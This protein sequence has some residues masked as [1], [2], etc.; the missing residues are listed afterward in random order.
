MTKLPNQLLSGYQKYL[1][2]REHDKAAIS[3]AE[4]PKQ[5]PDTLVI[6][7][8]EV[9]I[10]AELIFCTNPDEVMVLRSFNRTGALNGE[11]CEY[12]AIVEYA[13]RSLK[14]KHI[15]VLGNAKN[16]CETSEKCS[17][18]EGIISKSA[19]NE[20]CQIIKNLRK[21]DYVR[22]QEEQGS[23]SLHATIIHEGDFSLISIDVNG[24]EIKNADNEN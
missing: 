12:D 19:H 15:V 16:D 1:E 4:N 7:G 3:S 18:R 20:I 17:A 8:C 9:S 13:V 2:R 24:I 22:K 10:A 6:I 21:L 23:L 5:T 11:N 14:I